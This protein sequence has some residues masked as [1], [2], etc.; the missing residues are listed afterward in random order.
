MS[1]D[2]HDAFRKELSRALKA[3]L[4][5]SPYIL[6][7][8]ALI[9]FVSLPGS[10][11][12]LCALIDYELWNV[13]Q[14][15]AWTGFS[16]GLLALFTRKALRRRA[17]CLLLVV[18]IVVNLFTAGIGYNTFVDPATVYPTTEST[19]FLTADHELYRIL[20]VGGLS[21]FI[22][23][24]PAVYGI[25]TIGG[26]YTLCTQR[27]WEYASLIDGAHITSN[28]VLVFTSLTE[29]KLMDLLNV[30]YEVAPPD[31]TD[32]ARG[33]DTVQDLSDTP[34]GE[35]WGSNA[36]G[37]TFVSH[38]ANLTAISIMMATYSRVNTHNT[39]FHLRDSPS[40]QR[41]IVTIAVNNSAVQNNA[42]YTLRFPP[43]GESKNKQFYFYLESPDSFPGDA[44]TV[45]FSSVDAYPEG[46]RYLNGAPVQGD[47]RFRTFYEK[48]TNLKLVYDGEVRIY[49]NLAYLPRAFVVHQ[50]KVITDGSAILKELT[51][52]AF[53][54]TRYVILE[55]NVPN[56]MPRDQAQLR[57]NSQT[58]VTSYSP[59]RIV[60]NTNAST[61]GFLVLSDAY[62]S[63]W[64][65][66]VD[67]QIGKIY[68]ADYI[69]R[70]VYLD[71][72]AHTVEFIYNPHVFAVL[73]C[74][75]LSTLLIVVAVA[76]LAIC[77]PGFAKS[78]RR[79]PRHLDS[80][81]TSRAV[82]QV[83]LEGRR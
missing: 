35:I 45:W 15:V 21:T 31:S 25:S 69:L 72:G 40:S 75:S 12:K 24:S 36:D 68:V 41:D 62:D 73:L 71:K 63:N 76:I 22:P 47:L 38:Y 67:G 82:S 46:G 80:E 19:R 7:L 32:P 66:Y 5:I 57:E 54:P 2:M 53:D 58:E 52:D 59:S 74:V 37:Q 9:V 65:A 17:F 78:L 18:L 49:Q 60:I 28:G 70:A 8:L 4:L 23:N 11:T 44:I 61:S 83:P 56:E 29:S 81:V 48:P 51:S 1:R 20:P 33:E 55:E 3:L 42:Y 14:L 64:E 16:L 26:Y 79:W 34:V 39:I 77:R 30:K 43:I 50:T 6:I 27:Y 13:L 10:L